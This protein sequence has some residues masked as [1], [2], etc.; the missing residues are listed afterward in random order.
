MREFAAT[1]PPDFP[2]PNALTRPM[3]Q[4][5]ARAGRSELMSLW[6]GQSLRLATAGP[7][8]DIV[9]RLADGWPG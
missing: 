2:I 4:A 7:A 3:R 5:A 6:A 1:E 8:A 9:R